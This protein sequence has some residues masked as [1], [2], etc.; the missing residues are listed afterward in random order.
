M[1]M[2]CS[3]RSRPATLGVAGCCEHAASAANAAAKN[4]LSILAP[5]CMESNLRAA[6]AAGRRW[7]P[8]FDLVAVRVDEPSEAA[9]FMLF[10]L[11]HNP[12]AAEMDLPQRFI[13]IVDD[14]VEHELML[15]R[16]KIIGV[17]GKRAE[18]REAVGGERLRLK[19]DRV[20]AVSDAEPL[21][22]PRE[23]PLRIRRLEKES[24][25]AEHL[26]HQR[27]FASVASSLTS[28]RT[29]PARSCLAVSAITSPD[30]PRTTH[31]IFARSSVTW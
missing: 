2:M 20:L 30:L 17:G 14:Q 22:V 26:R 18:H 7:L 11:T 8:E 29:V 15:R 21:R 28:M 5:T 12:R 27:P 31:S 13:E 6:D 23:Q 24:T 3:I 19:L 9:V 1:T 4:I 25:Q 10:D 16:R